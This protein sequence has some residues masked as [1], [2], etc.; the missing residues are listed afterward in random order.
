MGYYWVAK[1]CSNNTFIIKIDDDVFINIFVVLDMIKKYENVLQSFIGG[2][3]KKDIEFVRDIKLKYYVSYV[4][5]LRKRFF[6]YCSGI[7]YVISINVVKRV[8]EVFRNIFFFYLE[9]VYIVFCLDYLNFILQNIEGFNI[10]YDEDEYVDL[11]ELK[12]NFVLVVYNF[13][14]RFFFIKEI[15]NKYCDI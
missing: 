9:D 6:G 1:Y 3:C 2:F 10:V 13:K 11:C 14:K 15:W 4:E 8:I 7:G 12:S 5:Y